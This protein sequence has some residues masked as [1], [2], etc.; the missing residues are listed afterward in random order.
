MSD[1]TADSANKKQR[2]GR[3]LGSL[4]GNSDVLGKSAPMPVSPGAMPTP[5]PTKAPAVEVPATLPTEARIWQ[6]AIDK[7]QA[8]QFQPRKQFVKEKLEELAASIKQ[9][10][11][12]QPVVA[13]KL[14]SGKFEII[15][16]ERRWRAAQ[17]A[18]LHEVPVILKTYSNKETLE[19]AIIENIQR[20]DLNP[21]EEAEAYQRL[22]NEFTLTQQQVADKVGKD[23]AT[24]AN[25]LRLLG[26]APAARTLL[27]QGKISAGHAKV[28]LSV[29]DKNQQSSLANKVVDE[30]LSVRAL[31]KLCQKPIV[32]MTNPAAVATAT[33]A[34]RVVQG[35]SIELQKTLGT[36]VQIDYKSGKGKLSIN[37]YSDDELTRLVEKLKT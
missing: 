27:L 17:L 21:I 11:I 24:V 33:T 8:S 26:L 22:I 12:L 28:L 2:L 14:N 9:N 13:R 34:D 16:G 15:A 18:G 3:G 29:E 4:L 35:L 6:V 23:R 1:I 5:V 37:F 20:E 31:E 25:S 10:G 30:A 36:K 19:L 7:L 32:T